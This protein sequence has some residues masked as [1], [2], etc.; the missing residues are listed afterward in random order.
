MLS[1]VSGSIFGGIINGRIGYYTPLA[2]IGTC[3]MCAGAGLLTTLEVDTSAGKWIGYQILYG[4]GLGLCFQVPNLATQT[5]LPRE[6][7][8]TGLALMLFGSLVGAS[9]FVAVGEN[10]LSNQLV[11]RLSSFPDFDP[12]VIKSGGVTSLLGSLPE[13][14]RQTALVAYNE[15][16]RTVCVVGLVLSCLASLGTFSLEWKSVKKNKVAEAAVEDS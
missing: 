15:A 4:I 12:G 8:P 9:V 11:Q 2:I 10:V 16:L 5:C 6:D 14:S 3:I 13:N 7:V 1:M